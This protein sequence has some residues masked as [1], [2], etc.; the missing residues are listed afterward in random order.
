MRVH[1]F[2]H[3]YARLSM[4]THPEPRFGQKSFYFL[5]YFYFINLV[6]FHMLFDYV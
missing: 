5:F 2:E 4:R 6:I 1:I 3:A